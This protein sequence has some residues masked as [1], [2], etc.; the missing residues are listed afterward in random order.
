M[1]SR[2]QAPHPPM[3]ITAS[4]M[5]TVRNR[6]AFPAPYGCPTDHLLCGQITRQNYAA[7]IERIDH[8]LGQYRGVIAVRG[9]AAATMVCLASDHG[10]MLADRFTTAKSKPWQSAMSVYVPARA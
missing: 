7:K 9:E 3:D 1:A 4:M 8:W 5:A 10:E 2:P 6:T